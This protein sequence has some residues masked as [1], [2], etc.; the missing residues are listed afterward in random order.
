MSDTFNYQIVYDYFMKKLQDAELM[1]APYTE[2]ISTQAMALP[3]L[4]NVVNDYNANR[5][6]ENHIVINQYLTDLPTLG[7]VHFLMFLRH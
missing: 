6:A 5:P 7:A 3:A 1:G 4:C 2:I